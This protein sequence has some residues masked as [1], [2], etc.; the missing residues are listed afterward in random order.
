MVNCTVFLEVVEEVSCIWLYL[1]MFRGSCLGLLIAI[2]VTL[3]KISI[4]LPVQSFQNHF[5]VG[6]SFTHLL[7]QI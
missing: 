5:G 4:C 1:M 6:F 2:S 7:V 3:D